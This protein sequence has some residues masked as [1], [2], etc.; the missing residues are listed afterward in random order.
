MKVVWSRRAD[1]H[2]T[3]VLLVPWL[4]SIE[5]LFEM[6]IMMG[7]TSLVFLPNAFLNH[8]HKI[9]KTSNLDSFN[10]TLLASWKI[11]GSPVVVIN[12]CKR[13]EQ[14]LHQKVT[15]SSKKGGKQKQR[16]KTFFFSRVWKML[17]P[18]TNPVVLNHRTVYSRGHVQL[19]VAK[20]HIIQIPQPT[21]AR[22][23]AR[24]GKRETLYITLMASSC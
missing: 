9:I 23:A 21:P 24:A 6:F 11:W 5:V 12:M 22:T 19:Q 1:C 2:H 16:S 8:L 13:G 15:R 4:S 10:K 17:P 14:S 20:H 18:K 7:A 3:C